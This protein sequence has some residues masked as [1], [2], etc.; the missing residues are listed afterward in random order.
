MAQEANSPPQVS[1]LALTSCT[2]R[3]RIRF[4]ATPGQTSV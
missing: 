4:R 3:S 1:C 2:Q